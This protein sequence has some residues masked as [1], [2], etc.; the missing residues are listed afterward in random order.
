[1][2]NALKILLII[3][4]IALLVLIRAFET[5]LFYDPLLAFFK[6]DHTTMALPELDKL[7][8]LV[9]VL[10][11]FLLNTGVSIGILWVLFQNRGVV[12]FSLVLY[13]ILALV[14]GIL[15][16]VLLHISEAGEHM[17]LFYV[18]RFLIQPLPLFLLVPAFYVQQRQ[19]NQH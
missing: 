11:R 6:T 19:K 7:K 13:G 9:H 2:N 3:I 8:T 17:L 10:F 14:L 16:Y 15:L 5:D 1:M 12:L 4:G 18:R